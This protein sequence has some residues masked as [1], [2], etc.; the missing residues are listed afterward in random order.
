ME[1]IKKILKFLDENAE[2]YLTFIFYSYLT[3]IIIIEVI[4]R[5]VFSASTTYGEETARYAFIWMTYIAA[6]WAVKRKGH[7][8]VDVLKS[9]MNQLQKYIVNVISDLCFLILAVTLIYYSIPIIQ[10]NIEMGHVMLGIDLPMVIATLSIPICWSLI[11]IRI[12]QRFYI[13]TTNFLKG[14]KIEGY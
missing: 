7:L 3:L 1:Q 2:S 6:A 8:S 4:R 14:E 10:L 13:T 5:Y 11:L 12:I 9:K